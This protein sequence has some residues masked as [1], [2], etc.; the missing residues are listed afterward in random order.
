MRTR[1]LGISEISG[2]V[3]NERKAGKTRKCPFRIIV[4]H[5]TQLQDHF[6]LQFL[7]GNSQSYL[8]EQ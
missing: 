7:C 4:F 5:N 3:T 6:F 1:F 2:T 8:A